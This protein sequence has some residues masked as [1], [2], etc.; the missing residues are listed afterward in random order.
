MTIIKAHLAATEVATAADGQVPDAE[1]PP[2]GEAMN[3]TEEE[4]FVSKNEVLTS[5]PCR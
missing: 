5:A 3:V 2:K 4:V 1:T